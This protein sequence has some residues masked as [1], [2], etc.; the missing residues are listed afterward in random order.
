[1]GKEI[2]KPF[3]Y[4]SGLGH[5]FWMP[6][7]MPSHAILAYHRVDYT[8]NEDLLLKDMIVEPGEFAWQMRY[9][10]NN[11]EVIKVEDLV[12][13]LECQKLPKRA[14]AITFDD[15]YEDNFNYAM[16]IL[17]SFKLP[18]TI[19]LS[20]DYIETEKSFFWDEICFL[21]YEAKE[22]FLVVPFEGKE[23]KFNIG[24]IKEKQQ[25]VLMLCAWLKFMTASNRNTVLLDISQRIN[26]KR[27]TGAS[28]LL[29]WSQIRQMLQSGVTIGAHTQQHESAGTQSESEFI[30]EAKRSKELIEQKLGEKVRLFAY[31]FGA[32]QDVSGFCKQSLMT[33]GFEGAFTMEQKLIVPEADPFFIP[34]IGIGG[35]DSRWKFCLKISGIMSR[36]SQWKRAWKLK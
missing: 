31:P 28:R 3:F 32:S 22:K 5:F 18:S 11:Y 1:M 21:V 29:S 7:K 6:R 27:W 16:P 13:G 26:V 36:L 25:V 4:C 9:L 10:K 14:V 15:G 35:N 23:K 24:T 30:F 12:G 17:C 8:K 19:F 34:R 2:L 20:T 33:L